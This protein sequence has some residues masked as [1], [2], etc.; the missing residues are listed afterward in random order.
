MNNKE[1][2]YWITEAPVTKSIIHMAVPMMLGMV[3]NIVYNLTDTFFIGK[4]N[5]T[6]ALA[7]MMLALPF[8]TVLMA[9]GNLLGVGG[10]TYISRLIGE[11]QENVAKRVSATVFYLSLAISTIFMAVSFLAMNLIL[12]ILGAKEM[13]DLL[14]TKSYI[15]I[16]AIASPIMITNFMFEQVVRSDGSSKESMTG[17]ILSVIVNMILDPIFI[18][19]LGL[20][21]RG[22]AIATVIG[23]ICAVVYYMC[24]ISLKDAN[25][26]IRLSNCILKRNVLINIF[27]VGISAMLLDFFM[28]VYGILFNNYAM[29]YGDSVVAGFGISQK[30]IQIVELVSMGIYTGI[31]PL[32]AAAYSSKNRTRFFEIL[33]KS[34]LYL[35]GLICILSAFLFVFRNSVIGIFTTDANVIELGTYTL[36]VQLIATFFAAG[37]GLFI[38]IFQAIGK[39]LPSTIMSVIRGLLL[40]PTL[41]LMNMWL[42]VHGVILSL[43][44]TDG[45]AFL[46]G[47]ILI[48]VYLKEIYNGFSQPALEH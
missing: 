41:A 7:A 35:I 14:Y 38:S 44:V 30:I 48:F 9:F 1:S 31:I 37:A 22:A 20:G 19:V 45:I 18:F 24:Y 26:S 12:P 3:V 46:I 27:K 29:L 5:S 39:G 25:L 17:T 6:G 47:G 15:E 28:I 21:V 33:K 42:H 10:S 4:L 43:V 23:N 34:A 36:S 11:K 32:V 2:T 40:I 8:T 13:E 16:F